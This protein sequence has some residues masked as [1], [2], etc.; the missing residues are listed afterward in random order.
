MIHVNAA[1]V[2]LRNC[3]YTFALYTSEPLLAGLPQPFIVSLS[4]GSKEFD[5]SHYLQVMGTEGLT[6][7]GDMMT[8]DG[9]MMLPPVNPYD[10]L[11]ITL[12]LTADLD[13]EPT[14][15]L[16]HQ[17]GPTYLIPLEVFYCLYLVFRE[18]LTG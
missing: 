6:V 7:Q 9:R 5:D 1:R 10:T 11:D 8:D 4:S 14:D 18:L 16:D 13:P 17:V 15:Q 3:V 12:T 2:G